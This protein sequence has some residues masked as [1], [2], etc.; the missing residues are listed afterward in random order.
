VKKKVPVVTVAEVTE[1]ARVAEL[2]LEAT[3]ALA[4]VAGAIKDGLLAF[5]SVTGLVVMSQMMQAELTEAIGSKHAKLPAGERTGNWHG[6]TTGSVV[7]GGR[8]VKVD[9]PRARTT[10]GEEIGLDTWKAFSFA[11][12]LNSLVV[13]RMLAAWRLVA[14]TT[15]QSRSVTRSRAG[16][17]HV[18]VDDLEAVRRCHQAGLRRAH[19]AQPRLL[20]D[21]QTGLFQ[22]A[23]GTMHGRFRHDR[24]L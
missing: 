7:L 17:S 21:E 18:E 10:A 20:R 19:G 8:L 5:A 24:H 12:L 23:G 22:G 15:S 11:D 2:P 13:E 1:A 3:V 6:T 14:T 4:E 16:R 9:R